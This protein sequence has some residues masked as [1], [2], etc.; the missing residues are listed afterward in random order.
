MP[1]ADEVSRR[2]TDHLELAL[3][4]PVGFEQTTTLLEC[5]TLL[6]DSLP[7]LALAEVELG[8]RWLGKPLRAP[9]LIAAMT[10]GTDRACGINRELAAIAERRGYA[11]G[12]GS[13][14]PML[15]VPE[16]ISSFDVRSVAP[17]ALVLGN[18]GG[19][20]AARTELGRLQELVGS[21]GADA[22]CVHLNPAQEVAQPGGDAD[23]RGVLDCLGRLTE[24]LGVPVI[25]KETGCGISPSVARRLRSVGVRHVDVSGAGGTSWVAVEAERAEASQRALGDRFRE[26]GIPTAAAVAF[27]ASEGFESVVASGGIAHG[28][29]AARAL[30]LGATVA[31]AA[32]PVL[33]ALERGGPAGAEAYLELMERELRTAMLLTASARVADLRRAGR[34]IAEPLRSW[35]R[36]G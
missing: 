31:G 22:L 10:G 21:I 8:V 28:L 36:L 5:V 27:C 12:L 16:R 26:W 14:R 29:D 17:T 32:R 20:Q 11:F 7:E 30:S 15:E 23:F 34:F 2:K 25:A 33:Q 13:Q 9:L 3:H 35:L 6:H 1:D 4:G 19:V 18:I 24:E